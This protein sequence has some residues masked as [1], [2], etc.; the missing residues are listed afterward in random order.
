MDDTNG[1]E[2][3]R[4]ACVVH[5]DG[6]VR[7]RSS[8][9]PSRPD[10]NQGDTM[11]A[12]HDARK[13]WQVTVFL[14]LFMVVNFIDKIALGMLAVP[15]MTEMK[16]TP[17]QFGLIG[18][19][20]FWLFAVSGVAGG[21]ATTRWSTTR[22]LLVMGVVWSLLQIPMAV[23]ASLVSLV[24]CRVLLGVAE[25]PAFPIAVHACYK[26]FPDSKRDLPVSIFAQGGGVGLLLAGVSIPQISAH[27]GWRANFYVLA[28]IG[29]AWCLLW[30][31]F[32]RE[33]PL[34]THTTRTADALR[35][36]YGRQEKGASFRTL[37]CTPT[38]LA[39]FLLHF[40]AYWSLALSLTWLP[41]YLQLGLGYNGVTSGRL[42]A[43]I[44]GGGIPLSIAVSWL[45]GR[46]LARGVSSRIAR[47]FMSGAVL[48]VA[49]ICLIALVLGD[50][51][52]SLHVGLMCIALGLVPTV[53]ALVP[54]LLAEIAPPWRRGALLAIDNSI[55]SIA[56]VMAP[57]LTGM[58]VEHAGARGSAGYAAGFAVC[59][60]M[61]I[62]GGL[63]GAAFID[64]RRV[65][66][67]RVDALGQREPQP[68]AELSQSD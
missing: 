29:A 37:L 5:A 48:T 41:A 39:C 45:V 42:Y 18:S 31:L 23:S 28:A 30:L 54:A 17:T 61:M 58:L 43:L 3:I 36:G 26:W 7:V 6:P 68:R 56:A 46:L 65:T 53:Y 33:G 63:L 11:G 19:S 49:G 40:V 51:A 13:A 1:R 50:F 64:P 35:P 10:T 20:F 25:G 14:F 16:I 62:I 8:R 67:T 47:G 21:F 22:L 59:G 52:P 66:D 34:E 44:V 27:W 55:A 9:A 60:A 57:V 12:P 2:S 32:G 24:L 4:T 38:V 15:M